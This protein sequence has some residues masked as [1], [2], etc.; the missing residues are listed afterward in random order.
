MSPSR[1]HLLVSASKES[2]TAAGRLTDI[3]NKCAFSVIKN[4]P[5]NFKIIWKEK[6]GWSLL[7][8][9]SDNCYLSR[10][11]LSQV[12]CL[13][14][15]VILFSC[16]ISMQLLCD[17]HMIDHARLH[18]ARQ[19]SALRPCATRCGEHARTTTRTQWLQYDCLRVQVTHKFTPSFDRRIPGS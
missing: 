3:S 15:V 16:Q 2:I 11:F 7:Q 13:L 8:C 12:L 9:D 17:T 14:R 6:N 4:A 1:Q 5:K 10:M 19:W 18:I